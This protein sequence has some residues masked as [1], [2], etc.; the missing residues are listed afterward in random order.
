MSRITYTQSAFNAGLLSPKV[1]KRIETDQYYRG[2]R[3]L[4]NFEIT[5]QGPAERR[6]GYRFV[7]ETKDSTKKSRLIP[8]IFSDIDSYAMEFGEGYIRFFRNFSVVTNAD[9]GAG[10]TATDPY[11]ISTSY[12][13]SDLPKIKYAQEGDIMY[14]TSG[15]TSIRPQK[16]TRQASGQFTIADFENISGPVLD[17]VKQNETLT[18]SAVSGSITVTASGATFE[19]G[20]VGS[21]WEIRNTTGTLASRGY[22]RIT[23]FTSATQ[24]DAD[25][26]GDNLFG[27]TASSYWGEAAWSGVR[28][29]PKAI[30]FH[31]QRLAFAATNESPLSVYFSK[32]NANYENF[33]YA[34]TN[35]A[36]A[37]NVTLSGQKNTIQWIESDINFLVAGTYGGLAFV[38]SSNS[39]QALSVTNV[40]ARNG[41][42]FGSSIVQG[43]RFGSG[44]KYIQS[45]GKRLYQGIYDDISLQYRVT[46]LTSISDE[47]LTGGVTYSFGQTEPYETLWMI[48]GDGRLV[49]FTEENEQ[50]VKAFH[51]HQTDGFFE[52]VCVVP[53]LGQDQQWVIVNRTVNSNTVRYVEYKEPDKT[54]PF[55][56]DSGVE[57]NG[58]QSETLTL[59]DTT[60]SGVTATAGAASFVSGDVGRKIFTFD[61]QGNPVGRATITAVTSTTVVTVNITADFA[62]T[63]IDADGWY[64]TA[65]NITGLDHLE[66][67]SV[68]V[69]VDGWY[70][71]FETVTSGEIT[72]TNAEAGAV[73]YIG[74]QYNSDL[75]IQPIERGSRN[76]SSVSKLRRINRVG[77]SLYEANAFKIGR[78]FEH[79]KTIPS[80]K[81]SSTMNAAVS[82]FG[83]RE[84]QDIVRSVNGQWSSDAT[85]C[86]RQDFPVGLTLAAMTMYMEVSYGY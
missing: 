24:V 68:Q 12:T 1:S 10:G 14:L 73:I 42:D 52:S 40:Q 38:G 55:F 72:L 41:E 16:L 47:V 66:G 27:T 23:A 17:V 79:L 63:S 6:R 59:S 69:N 9:V 49:G 4:K 45:G 80:R 44:I 85:V 53:N 13:E 2:C 32:S 75:K 26:V 48:A 21:L 84:V 35:D 43:I 8:F 77:L 65:T 37:F 61:S 62:D 3:V 67:K 60:G 56:V 81:S 28:G 25:V 54:L 86:V 20:H 18:A 31:E 50:E 64:L 33:D 71:G 34:E 46:D 36:D 83:K 82:Q 74:L 57:Y 51:E 19:S 30:S 39:T 58:L 7:L 5:P 78:D 29:Y 70:A 11:E 15:G 76:G 22:F